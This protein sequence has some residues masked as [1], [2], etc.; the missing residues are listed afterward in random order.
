M[1]PTIR[2]RGRPSDQVSASPGTKSA[3]DGAASQSLGLARRVPPLDGR[4]PR[5]RG[6]GF[7]RAGN[8][9]L[10]SSL[11]GAGEC[12]PNPAIVSL[13]C[14]SSTYLGVRHTRRPVVVLAASRC[15]RPAR[16]EENLPSAGGRK[17]ESAGSPESLAT[18]GSLVERVGR[19]VPSSVV[20]I[21]PEPWRVEPPGSFEF[22]GNGFGE[23]RARDR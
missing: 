21:L 15:V 2:F 12:P 23:R 8:Q 19:R 13:A 17:R 18:S 11:H 14:R 1:R 9:L 4:N 16:R 6:E 20:R 3:Y 5:R 10:P 22:L 7:D